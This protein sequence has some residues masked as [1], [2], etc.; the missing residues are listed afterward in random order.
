MKRN[1][2]LL[3]LF[4]VVGLFALSS[5]CGDDSGPGTNNNGPVCNNDG[6]C[7]PAEIN[8]P[9]CAD[10]IS[11]CDLN[12]SGTD[13]DF[14]VQELFIPDTTTAAKEVG[15][16]MDGDGDAENRLGAIISA[17]PS[18]SFDINESVN[19]TIAEGKLL[20]IG[21][22]HVDQF[23]T[24]DEMYAQVFQGEV[25][26]DA[27]PDFSGL[28]DQV[29][30]SSSSPTDLLLCG[31]IVADD[32]TVGPADLAMVFPVPEIGNLN[33]TLSKAQMFG[34]VTESGWT[35][36]VIWGAI[37][38]SNLDA[39][40]DQIRPWL[41][42]QITQDPNGSIA[43]TVLDLLDKEGSCSTSVDGC[44]PLPAGCEED[45]QISLDEVKC[46]PLLAAALKPDVDMD[47][48]GTPDSISLGLKVVK[49]TPVTVVG[50]AQ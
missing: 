17:I 35:D 8:N 15:V 25:V 13:H 44:D 47:G 10:C 45:G 32:M 11:S 21:R 9:N 23:G 6:V 41:N 42:D 31:R 24:D 36:V 20:L 43:S 39:L 33:V 12:S 30:I 34:T 40:L 28:D 22:V 50:G 37:S 1:R 5:A 7:D 29:S 18:S 16:D 46:N 49:A 3:T 2:K 38:K 27:T 26:G 48:D 14:L 19:N 4:G